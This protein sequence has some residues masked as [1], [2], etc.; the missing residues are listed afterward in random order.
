MEQ[1]TDP[2][3]AQ[4]PCCGSARKLPGGHWVISWGGTDLITEEAPGRGPVFALRFPEYISYR[5][6][7]VLP[8]QLKRSALYR[9]MDAMHPR[10]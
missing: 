7:P 1:I 6:F 10:R 5:A 8:G 9:G 3:A 2:L 4:S